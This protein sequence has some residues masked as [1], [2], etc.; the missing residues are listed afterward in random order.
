MAS[1]DEDDNLS[2]ILKTKQFTFT[3]I[4]NI[5]SSKDR[6]INA[7]KLYSEILL[8]ILAKSNSDYCIINIILGCVSRN[9]MNKN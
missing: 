5:K 9:T 1:N 3:E 6:D 8:P 7:E 4:K 2:L